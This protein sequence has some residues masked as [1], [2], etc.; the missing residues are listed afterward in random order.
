MQPDS[1]LGARLVTRGVGAL[2][3][4][5]IEDALEAGAGCAR[6][7]LAAR[8]IDGAALRLHGEMIVVGTRAIEIPGLRAPLRGRAME[9]ALHV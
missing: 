6:K 4:G 1:D 9:S 3:R 7:L 5:E 8:L 2:S